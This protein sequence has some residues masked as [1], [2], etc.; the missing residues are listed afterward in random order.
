MSMTWWAVGLV[1]I[2]RGWNPRALRHSAS[3][4]LS[5]RAMS[6]RPV[7]LGGG[8]GGSGRGQWRTRSEGVAAGAGRKTTPPADRDA[9]W[10]PWRTLLDAR[11]AEA[12]TRPLFS[13]T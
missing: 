1:D 11:E 12:Y 10:V 6:V 7:A 8:G 2:A 4:L 5:R 13:S 3:Y 9:A